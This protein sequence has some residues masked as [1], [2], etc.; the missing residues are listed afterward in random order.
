MKNAHVLEIIA[1]TSRDMRAVGK[2]MLSQ[3]IDF[4]LQIEEKIVEQ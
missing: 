4:V 3:F 2:I 1:R